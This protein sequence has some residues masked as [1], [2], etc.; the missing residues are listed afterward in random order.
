M[1]DELFESARTK[2]LRLEF[3]SQAKGG[4]YYPV[5]K[6]RLLRHDERVARIDAKLKKHI[7]KHMGIWTARE[8]ARLT[9][10]NTVNGFPA[11][12]P[13]YATPDTKAKIGQLAMDRVQARCNMRRS[14][15][16]ETAQTMREFLGGSPKT[17]K[18][19]DIIKQNKKISL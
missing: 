8:H 17:K 12:R 15:F 9:S 18:E 5:Q 11:P 1:S 13:R 7:A 16:E 4:T 10:K 6:E 14:R 2:G 19:M 3:G